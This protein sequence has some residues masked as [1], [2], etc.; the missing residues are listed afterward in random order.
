MDAKFNADRLRSRRG[1][2]LIEVMVTIFMA[3]FFITVTFSIV[4]HSNR[5]CRAQERVSAVQQELRAGLDLMVREIRMAGYNPLGLS[6]AGVDAAEPTS[7][8]FS[9]DIDSSNDLDTG[10]DEQITY[11]WDAENRRV[12]RSYPTAAG[13]VGSDVLIENVTFLNFDYVY[14]DREEVLDAGDP[15]QIGRVIITISCRD[16]DARGETFVRTLS[17]SVQLRNFKLERL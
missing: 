5:S 1:F 3:A 13:G 7:F 8:A 4:D 17:S 2:T 14:Y 10:R 12:L 16:R 11:S 6:G 9:M 15:D